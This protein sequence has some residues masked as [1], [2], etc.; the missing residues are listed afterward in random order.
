MKQYTALFHKEFSAYFY[1]MNAFII[2]GAYAVLSLF[3]ALYPGNYFLRETDAMNAFFATQPFILMLIIPAVT[4]RSWSEEIKSGTFELLITQPIGYFALVFAKFTAAYVFFIS[5][6]TF[7]I[8]LL[9]ISDI[10]SLTDG[11]VILSAYTGLL[12]CGALFTAAGCFVSVL[13][14]NNIISYLAAIFL[15]FSLTQIQ[16][17]SAGGEKIYVPWDILNFSH[18]Y[19]AFTAGLVVWGNAAYFFIGTIIFLWMNTFFL[20]ARQS[21]CSAT[22]KTAFVLLSLLIFFCGTGSIML[23]CD[24]TYDFTESQ[25]YALLQ[26]NREYLHNLNK[27]IN[28]T[29]YEAKAKRE[30]LNSNYAAHARYI[31]RLL[32]QI[33]HLSSGSVRYEIIRAESLS[34]LELRLIRE[35]IPYEEDNTGNKI[36]MAADFSDN[37]GNHL[38][39]DSFSPFRHHFAETDIIR[40]IKLLGKEKKSIA[41]IASSEDLKHMQAFSSTL[42]EFYRVDYL[43]PDISFLPATYDAVAT[44]NPNYPSSQF[45]SALEQYVLNGGSLI[46]F[47]EP[48]LLRQSQNKPF[49]RFF[50]KFG[51]V[52]EIQEAFSE[53][54]DIKIAR[55]HKKDGKPDIDEI[56]VG[57]TKNISAKP[58]KTYTVEPL[59][60]VDEKI[61]A[62]RSSGKYFTDYPESA[63][64]SDNFL[65]FSRK[66][67]KIYF[68]YDSD[69]I[70]DYLY[71]S[72]FSKGYGFYQNV[73]TA[74]NTL[75]ILNLTDEAT[76]SNT[77]NGMAYRRY[78][79][80]LSSIGYAISDA[81]KKKYAAQIADLT[82]QAE[83][84]RQKNG[85]FA[86]LLKNNGFSSIKQV[87]NINNITQKID[88]I[89]DELNRIQ[90]MINIEYKNHIAALTVFIIFIIPFITL[91]LLRLILFC[92]R[93]RRLSKIRRLINDK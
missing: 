36:Y 24:T 79:V 34:A 68:I 43:K 87:G 42:N 66:S 91:M 59:L 78:P 60:S 21:D 5:A 28:I 77:E 53:E 89:T 22:E 86:N 19:D 93:K 83:S 33:E 56:I 84:Y 90:R 73:P 27:R 14:K 39:I 18:N 69:L 25:R 76:G 64:L 41:V 30:D 92:I 32:K 13:C 17:N 72:E 49:I 12:L 3:S 48:E 71:S 81:V 1:G 58:G 31:E 10:F 16:F 11:G 52:P 40:M 47:Y 67:G 9:V 61:T 57:D 35:N 54:N 70:R 45:L 15:L 6:V 88:E 8:P 62:L 29:L 50:D 63:A 82:R 2:L 38:R 51:I 85:K 7:S 20:A 23:F 44:I 46:F 80:N 26:E 55:V 74:D 75:F 65:R 4:M 37:E